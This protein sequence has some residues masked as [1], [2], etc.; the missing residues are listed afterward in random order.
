MYSTTVSCHVRAPRSV[1]YRLLLDPAAVTQWR[2][3]DGMTSLV[4]QFEAHEGGAFRVSLS[5]DA[6]D[7]TGKSHGH[8]DTYHGRFVTLVPDEQVVEELEF[9]TGDPDLRGTMTM[10]TTLTDA[11]DGTDIEVVHEGLP[12]KVPAADNELG[13]SMALAKLA[14]LAESG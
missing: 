3:P 4:H 8:T 5:Y 9:E 13:T 10:R 6:P 12:D 14:R 11:A 7:R 2:V 1:V